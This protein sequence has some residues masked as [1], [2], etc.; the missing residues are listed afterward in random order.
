MVSSVAGVGCR[1]PLRDRVKYDEC[2]G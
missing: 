1:S 2:P